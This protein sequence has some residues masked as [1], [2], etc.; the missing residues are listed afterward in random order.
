MNYYYK[1]INTTAIEQSIKLLQAKLKLATIEGS[2]FQIGD[3]KQLIKRKRKE[4]AIAK[5]KMEINKQLLLQDLMNGK[6]IEATLI[7]DESS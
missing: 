1:H 3:C 6:K 7:K 4:L 5:A 2:D